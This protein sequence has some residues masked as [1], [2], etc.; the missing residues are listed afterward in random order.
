MLRFAAFA[1]CL[2]AVSQSNQFAL[3]T[4]IPRSLSARQPVKNNGCHFCAVLY[5][6]L[7]GSQKSTLDS[8]LCPLS[9]YF[10]YH[11]DDQFAPLL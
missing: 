2:L 7:T 8:L 1:A 6:D 5:R 3:F 11:R 4:R 10:T 9:G